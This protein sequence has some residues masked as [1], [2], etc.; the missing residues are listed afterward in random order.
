MLLQRMVL[1]MA[2]QKNVIRDF[3]RLNNCAAKTGELFC[4][5]LIVTKSA[6]GMIW[7]FSDRTWAVGACNRLGNLLLDEDSRGLG[8]ERGD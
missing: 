2:K 7:R 3:V 8:S 5:Y 6:S 1:Q 4:D